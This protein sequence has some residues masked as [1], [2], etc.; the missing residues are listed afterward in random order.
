[1]TLRPQGLQQLP[2]RDRALIEQTRFIGARR[3][4]PA[5]AQ[6]L[7]EQFQQR[8]EGENAFRWRL[9]G[10]RLDLY[11]LD[12]A[13]EAWARV[14]RL[15]EERL[16]EAE[17]YELEVLRG[18]IYRRLGRLDEAAVV[19]REAEKMRP[20]ED[21]RQREIPEWRESTVRSASYFVRIQ[22][23]IRDGFLP[24]AGEL[25]RRWE[26]ER[27]R[28]KLEGDFI[29]AEAEFYAA[30]NDHRRART[31][32]RTLRERET[33]DNFLPTAVRIEA[34]ALESLRDRAGLEEL[35][36]EIKKHL[37]GHEVIET[38][39]RSLRHVR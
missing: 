1:M 13:E 7:L 17:R 8:A 27:P 16:S 31:I 39:Q 26:W 14:E 36:E 30:I 10:I 9:E 20:A 32:A 38:V 25:L 28:Q 12:R 2:D 6:R 37:P 24:E 3:E 15:R 29:V 5:E 18:D 34:L 19:Y 35:L 22:Q 11:E 21:R 23:M 4:N 33:M